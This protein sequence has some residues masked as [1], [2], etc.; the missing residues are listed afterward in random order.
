MM[1]KIDWNSVEA[2]TPGEFD[3]PQADGYV[4]KIVAAVNDPQKQYLRLMLDIAEGDYKDIGHH[5]EIRTNQTW[6]YYILYRSYK[7]KARGMFKGFLMALEASNP[8]FKIATWNNDEKSFEGLLVGVVL[9]DEEY[10]TQARKIVT[11][12][13]P[14]RVLP[15]DDIRNG[16][17]K[18]PALKKLERPA[19]SV[20][21]QMAGS[22]APVDDDC[23]F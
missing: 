18:V 17:F 6:G 9:G 15:V 1:E 10:E 23:P 12:Q 14:V 7:E 3:R 11:V 16:N 22:G 13:R 4:M 21:P 19:S 2:T 20:N 5:T 8:S